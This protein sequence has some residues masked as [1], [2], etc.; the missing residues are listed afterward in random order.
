MGSTV[1]LPDDWAP[2]DQVVV[3]S[4][5]GSA[6]AGDLTADLAASPA[7]VPISV[8]RGFRL[9]FALSRRCLFVA[10]SYSGDT[11]ETL[12]L[13]HQA[14][15]SSSHVVVI[16]SGGKLMKEAERKGIPVLKVSI[17]GEPRGAAAY[18]L[19][20]ILSVLDRLGLLDIGEKQVLASA[21]DLKLRVSQLEEGIPTQ[22]NLAKQLAAE[23]VDRQ[24]LVYGG[25][26]LSGMARRWKSQFNE[27]AKVWAFCETIPELLH[28]LVEAV[29]ASSGIAAGA[30]VLLLQPTGDVAAL[31]QRFQ[32]VAEQ[33]RQN[34][35]PNRILQ[36]EE[37]PPLSQLLQMLL[38]GDYV[39]YYLALLR[40]VD[41]SPTPA[42]QEAKERL[43]GLHPQTGK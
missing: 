26:L 34:G 20:L 7:A 10:C 43:A 25:G 3:G 8:V 35:I 29:G 2:I 4:M 39:S 36:G 19:I 30:T 9:P 16:S 37:R 32:I 17:P 11:E 21:Q 40:G 5:G 27:N 24:V 41:P 15:E 33:L 1:S 6:I 18:S 14:L 42:I 31:D 12:S 28:N 23:L 22:D 13:F 38:L